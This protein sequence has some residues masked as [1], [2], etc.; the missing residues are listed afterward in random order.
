MRESS[1][2]RGAFQLAGSRRSARVL[3]LLYCLHGRILM[4]DPELF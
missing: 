1:E 2:E 3:V 4:A